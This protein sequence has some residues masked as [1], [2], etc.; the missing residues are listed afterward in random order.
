MTYRW[1]RLR[2]GIA[3]QIAMKSLEMVRAEFGVWQTVFSGSS[4][5]K[6]HENADAVNK[7]TDYATEYS[8]ILWM[9]TLHSRSPAGRAVLSH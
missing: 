5:M 9:I 3:A 7:T 8:A 1:L 2:K 6:T 4:S